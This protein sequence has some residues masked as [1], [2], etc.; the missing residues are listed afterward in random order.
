VLH[1]T[2]ELEEYNAFNG[3]GTSPFFVADVAGEKGSE[4]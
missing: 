1:G 4:T 3:M 2:T